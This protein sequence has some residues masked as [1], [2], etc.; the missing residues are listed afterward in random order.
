MECKQ[1]GRRFEIGSTR[2][3][4]NM[5]HHMHVDPDGLRRGTR[6]TIAIPLL[7]LQFRVLRVEGGGE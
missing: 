2:R 6:R 5:G 4:C 1:L 3:R 7:S